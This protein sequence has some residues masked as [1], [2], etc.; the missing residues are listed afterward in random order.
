MVATRITLDRR[1]PCLAGGAPW[2][3]MAKAR[4]TGLRPGEHVVWADSGGECAERCWQRDA[5]AYRHGVEER[6]NRGWLG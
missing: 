2:R 3:V 4:V 5:D 6:R 1:H